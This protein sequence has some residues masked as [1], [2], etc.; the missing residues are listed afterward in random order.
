MKTVAQQLLLVLIPLPEVSRV[1]LVC[2]IVE[3]AV[4]AIG[5]DHVAC[6]LK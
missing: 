2:H 5:D 4:V 6:L 3:N 1:N